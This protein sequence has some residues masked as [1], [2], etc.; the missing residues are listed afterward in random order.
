MVPPYSSMNTA[1]SLKKFGFL[2]SDD[3]INSCPLIIPFYYEILLYNPYLS[4]IQ[5]KVFIIP[6]PIKKQLAMFY[7]IGIIITD[8]YLFVSFFLLLSDGS[9]Q[10]Y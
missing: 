10:E 5:F 9:L 1:T 2:L 7:Y 6:M 8:T 4:I 3:C